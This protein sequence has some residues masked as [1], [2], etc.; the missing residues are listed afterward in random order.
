MNPEI[1]PH[2]RKAEEMHVSVTNSLTQKHTAMERTELFARFLSIMIS[3]HESILTLL[4]EPRLVG[5]ALALFR[6]LVETGF[7]GHFA[8]FLATDD[9]V[10][11]IKHGIQPYP[12]FNDMATSLDEIFGTS[13]LFSKYKGETWKALCGFTHSGLEQLSRRVR[14]DRAFGADYEPDLIVE[15]IN[16]STS[17]LVLTSIPYLQLANLKE[18]AKTVSDRYIALY[19]MQPK[20]P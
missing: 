5:S 4:R 17:A 10:Q 8:A 1:F 14:P 3:H 19:Q 7:R 6:P 11:A 20:T 13:G 12:H 9:Q 15:L 18:S 16:S 2:L